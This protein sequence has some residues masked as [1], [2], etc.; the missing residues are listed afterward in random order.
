MCPNGVKVG[1]GGGP[2]GRQSAQG[3]RDGEAFQ[4]TGVIQDRCAVGA[5]LADDFAEALG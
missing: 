3:H 1:Q 5:D 2:G 4:T